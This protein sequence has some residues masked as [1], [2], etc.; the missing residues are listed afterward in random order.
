MCRRSFVHIIG[1]R[2]N[3]TKAEIRIATANVIENSRNNRRRNG[4]HSGNRHNRNRRQRNLNA[5]R[6]RRG[7]RPHRN[8]DEMAGWQEIHHSQGDDPNLR[9][10]TTQPAEAGET[11]AE[12]DPGLQ[13]FPSQGTRQRRPATAT[14][15]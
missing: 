5:Q 3:E 10:K 2:V 13:F 9:N 4:S 12:N 8:A 6:L 15:I 11:G 7:A 14:R 1:V